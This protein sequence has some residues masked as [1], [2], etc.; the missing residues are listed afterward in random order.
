M[1][2]KVGDKVRFVKDIIYHSS[3][4]KIGEIYKIT[5]VS[6]SSELYRIEN[7]ECFKE[8]ELE[9]A[10]NTFKKSDLKDG[11][12]VTYRDGRKRT[13]KGKKIIDSDWNFASALSN[14]NN[15]LKYI[16]RGSKFDI[17]K[18]ER[19]IKYETIFE[20]KEE[21]LDE[22]EKEYL[23]AVIKP[24]RNE[25]KSIYKTNSCRFSNTEYL[26]ICF[27]DNDVMTFKNFKKGTMYKNMELDRKST[28]EELG[29]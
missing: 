28:L 18:V 3:R 11:D 1:K 17:V 4:T 8:E 10:T 2:F 23:K 13:V 9:L 27:K 6:N 20:R 24:F 14:W 12:I 19:P 26:E 29:L 7:G 5:N 15:N 25:I 21:I 16:D 22:I